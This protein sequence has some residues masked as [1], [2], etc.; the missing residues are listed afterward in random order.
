LANCSSA[1]R[2]KIINIVKNHNTVPAKVEEVIRMVKAGDG[3]RY[4]ED[5][6]KDYRDKALEM[7]LQFPQNEYSRSF[8]ELIRY[9]VD[10]N[11]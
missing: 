6:M 5:K 10:R 1:D 3:M 4:A 11:K 8:I 9:T 2:N 7:L